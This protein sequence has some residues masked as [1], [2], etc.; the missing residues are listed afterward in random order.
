MGTGVDV[1]AYLDKASAHA[2]ARRESTYV[3]TMAETMPII[4]LNATAT[5][6]PVAR[7]A[8]GSTSGVNA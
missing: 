8:D 2:Q 6:L 3:A 7:C 4:R 1:L 5:P